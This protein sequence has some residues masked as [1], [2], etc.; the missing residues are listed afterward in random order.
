MEVIETINASNKIMDIYMNWNGNAEDLDVSA[1][2]EKEIAMVIDATYDHHEEESEMG[3]SDDDL[4][5]IVIAGCNLMRYI[6]NEMPSKKRA[7]DYI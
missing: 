3:A 1:F 4:L 7:V 6:L 5:S 2:T